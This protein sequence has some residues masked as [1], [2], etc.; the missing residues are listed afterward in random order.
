MNIAKQERYLL[1]LPA[2]ISLV[3]VGAILLWGLKAG[4]DLTGGALLQVSYPGGRPGITEV[5]EAMSKLSF[6]EVRVQPTGDTGYII[7]ARDLTNDEKNTLES[8]L[9]TFGEIHEDQ[10][11]SVGPVIGQELLKKGLIALVLVAISI[12]LFIAFAF[13]KVSKPV[14]SWKYGIIAIVTLIHDI[15]IPVGLFA[16]LGHFKGS[17]IDSLFIVAL[18]TLLGV[19]INNTIVVF[20]RIRE[21]L[22]RN[23]EYRKKE[24]FGET[25]GRSIMQT[26]AR[27]MNTSFTV[28]IVLVALYVLG[29]VTTRDFALTLIVGMIAGTYSSIFL[30]SPLLVAWEKWQDQRK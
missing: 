6:G 19:S 22:R 2:I 24:I 29:P 28:I 3:A 17:E 5:H 1:L 25:V 9:A 30:A 7:R 10:F 26:L 27:S 12:I 13:R 8:T 15:L 18:L 16:V 21:N 4:I 23:E 14:A 20:D 11:N